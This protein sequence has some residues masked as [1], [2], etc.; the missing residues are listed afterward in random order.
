MGYFAQAHEGFYPDKTILDEILEASPG[1]LP[2]QGREYLGKYLFSGDDAF[3]KVSM[4]SGG[5]RGRL[6]LAKLALQDTNLLLLDETSQSSRY[7]CA[8]NLAICAG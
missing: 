1:M 5:E 8:G 7:S 2:Y 3:K 4:L 6:A